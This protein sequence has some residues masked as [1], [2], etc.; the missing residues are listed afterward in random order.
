MAEI[1]LRYQ[2]GTFNKPRKCVV[3]RDTFIAVNRLSEYCSPRCATRYGKLKHSRSQRVCF[4]C[5]RAYTSTVSFQRFCTM[6]CRRR[7]DPIELDPIPCDQ[8]G[9]GFRPQ[10]KWQVYCSHGCRDIH[11]L[12][13]KKRPSESMKD[14]LSRVKMY[15]SRRMALR[16]RLKIKRKLC[17]SCPKPLMKNSKS[18]CEKHWFMQIM[19][20]YGFRMKDWEMAKRILEGQN[21]TCPYTGLKLTKGVNASVDHKNP[22]SKFPGQRSSIE[23][24][25]W[26]DLHVNN[27]KQNLTKEEFKRRIELLK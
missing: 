7:P 4:R 3:C 12:H 20:R 5:K 13:S 2:R 22:K 15:Q 17:R 19:W 27:V 24:I 11:H 9:K 25:E 8:C 21:H 18:W 10:R 26:V 14:F 1:S 16:K 23:N 6:K